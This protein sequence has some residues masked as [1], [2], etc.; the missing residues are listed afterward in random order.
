MAKRTKKTK[1]S[2]RFGPRY[3]VSVKRQVMALENDASK[4]YPCPRCHY[5]SVKRVSSG[6]WGCRRCGHKFSAGTYSPT[7]REISRKTSEV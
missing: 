5:S 2:A 4:R 1:R 3:G 7:I 6:I